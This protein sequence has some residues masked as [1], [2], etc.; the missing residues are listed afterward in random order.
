MKSFFNY[1]EGSSSSVL[2][3]NKT[4]DFYR[5]F[6]PNL[7]NHLREYFNDGID[8]KEVTD[9]LNSTY[10]EN[11]LDYKKRCESKIS[12]LNKRVLEK[13]TIITTNN[14]NL[15]CKYCYANG[16][17]YGKKVEALS[18]EE[19]KNIIDYFVDKFDFI[20]T[21]FFFWWRTIDEFSS[22]RIYL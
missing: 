20:R 15:Q 10:S 13:L 2:F 22:Y 8:S 12:N 21:V 3:N 9:I 4:L 6:D 14:C 1:L 18:Y 16:G 5:I 11:E 17:N 7:K 19:A